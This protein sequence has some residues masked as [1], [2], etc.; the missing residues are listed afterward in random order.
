MKKIIERCLNEMNDINYDMEPYM[1]P[2]PSS[3]GLTKQD[4]EKNKQLYKQVEALNKKLQKQIDIDCGR[5]TLPSYKKEVKSLL[6]FDKEALKELL[7][8]H[9]TIRVE[10]NK[11]Y[12][13]YDAGDYVN[14]SVSIHF[15]EELISCDNSTFYF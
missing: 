2:N 11:E 15:D 8:E 1:K 7:K 6:T 4:K 14:V 13:S 10:A 3:N 9:L 5:T 12:G